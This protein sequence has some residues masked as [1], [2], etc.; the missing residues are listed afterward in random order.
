MEPPVMAALRVCRREYVLLL[1]A[2]RLRRRVP[3]TSIRVSCL[4][5]AHRLPSVTVVP[6]A[7][8]ARSALEDRAPVELQHVLRT[9]VSCEDHCVRTME[10]R[11]W[12]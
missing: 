12:L 7:A 2:V 6:G 9:S 11:V 5:H 1:V 10:R 3:S 8:L 4:E